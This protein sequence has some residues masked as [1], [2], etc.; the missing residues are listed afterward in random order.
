M[1][2]MDEGGVASPIQVPEMKRIGRVFTKK[3]PRNP[4][5]RSRNDEI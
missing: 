3:S 5:S 4:K 2:T 1:S